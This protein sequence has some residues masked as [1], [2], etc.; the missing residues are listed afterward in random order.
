MLHIAPGPKL[1]QRPAAPKLDEE[2]KRGKK[3]LP[4]SAQG[5]HTQ[6]VKPISSMGDI[7]GALKPP[8]SHTTGEPSFGRQ[9]HAVSTPSDVKPSPEPNVQASA[10]PTQVFPTSPTPGKDSV[11]YN[12]GEPGFGRQP[13]PVMAQH[14]DKIESGKIEGLMISTPYGRLVHPADVYI[15]KGTGLDR[16]TNLAIKADKIAKDKDR[17]A[18]EDFEKARKDAES[19]TKENVNSLSSQVASN[20]K[21]ETLRTKARD[22]LQ[23]K[24]ILEVA[25]SSAETIRVMIEQAQGHYDSAKLQ[26]S[27]LGDLAYAR[28]LKKKIEKSEKGADEVMKICN[29][30]IKLAIAIEKEDPKAAI[31]PTFELLGSAFKRFRDDSKKIEQ[32]AVETAGTNKVIQAVNEEI[33]TAEKTI[34]SA[35]EIFDA[36]SKTSLESI[37][38]YSKMRI[39]VESEYDKTTKGNFKFSKVEG[40]LEYLSLVIPLAY[41]AENGFQL[42][43]NFST[44]LQ[45]A[46]QNDTIHDLN[47]PRDMMVLEGRLTLKAMTEAHRKGMETNKS[48]RE[49]L[50][51]LRGILSELPS[52]ADKA[53]TGLY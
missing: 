36:A 9:P 41:A 5:N 34:S 14:P 32:E 33:D 22:L 42:A 17:D 2:R 52:E 16:I 35:T 18:Q 46:Y 3:E 26:L 15:Y 10:S 19:F 8:S 24:Q 21:D 38:L 27:G 50:A 39:N 43:L 45:E 40:I 31:S 48:R 7:K 47:D 51:H 25:K 6:G 23:Q 4:S 49:Q 37:E 28:E 20:S 29:S 30:L 44:T 11:F 53:M 13:K 12:R 1:E